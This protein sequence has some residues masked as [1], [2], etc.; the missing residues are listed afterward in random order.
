MPSAQANIPSGNQANLFATG[1]NA[2]APS[3]VP[4][5]ASQ[6]LMANYFSVLPFAQSDG[7]T[8]YGLVPPPG[9]FPGYLFPAQPPSSYQLQLLMTQQQQ[10]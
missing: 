2:Q 5:H 4:Q 10:Q 6:P 3:H 8:A 9:G 1:P 7:S